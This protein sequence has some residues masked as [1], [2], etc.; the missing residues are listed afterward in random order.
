MLTAPPLDEDDVPDAMLTPPLLP[1][2]AVPVLIVT[3]PLTP[4]V[5]ASTVTMLME[6]DDVVVPLPDR[7]V[8]LPPVLELEVPL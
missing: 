1:S 3:D 2:V 8:T 7:I 6:P 5:P 4:D